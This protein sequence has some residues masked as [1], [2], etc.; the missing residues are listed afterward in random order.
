M[1]A[2][3]A[4]LREACSSD[5]WDAGVRFFRADVVVGVEADEEEI[6]LHVRVGGRPSPYEVHLWPKDEDWS[7]DCGHEEGCAH[8]VAAVLAMRKSKGELP[9]PEGHSSLR[10]RLLRDGKTLRIRREVKRGDSIEPAPTLLSQVRGLNLSA[11]D[12]VI[13]EVLALGQHPIPA[14]GW[15]RILKGW[16]SAGSTLRLEGGQLQASSE[17]ITP[18]VLVRDEGRGFRLSLHRDSRVDERFVG[19]I[20]R[21]GETL[22][23]LGDGGLTATQRRQLA[24]GLVFRPEDA[25]LLVGEVL[26]RLEQQVTVRVKT[27]RLPSATSEPPRLVLSVDDHDDGL[28]VRLDIVYGDP[29]IARVVGDELLLTGEAVPLRDKIR[30]RAL[31][32]RAEGMRLPLGRDWSFEEDEAL[33]FVQGRLADFRG[34]VSGSAGRFAVRGQPASIALV[35]GRLQS[36]ADLDGLVDAWIDGESLVPLADGAGYA[37]MPHAFMA[38]HGH[39]VADLV[40]ARQADGSTPKF[41]LPALAELAQALDHPAPPELGE[42]RELLD[43]EWPTE[44]VPAS[45]QAALRPYQEQGFRWLRLLMRGGLGGIL[46]DDMGLGKTLQAL[47]AITAEGG[48][49]LVIAPTSVIGNWLAE[50]TKFVP[51]LSTNRF[52]GP[53]RRLEEVDITVT[54]YALLRLDPSLLEREWTTVVL[55]EAQA[56]K[57]PESQ[58]AQAAFKLRAKHRMSLTGTPIENRLDELWSQLHFVMPG[59]LG[60]RKHF[61]D[62][63]AR[64]VEHGDPRAAK[65]LRKRIAPFVLRRLKSEVATDLPP[66]TDVVL[67]CPM[68]P[69]Q[70]SLYEGV[71]AAAQGDLA[72]MLGDGKA[73][74]ILEVLLRL[75]QA[76]CHSRLLPG[77]RP[78][79]S[80][81]LE[82]LVEKLTSLA[83]AGHRCL[84]FSQWTSH[85]DLIEERVGELGVLRLD[86]ST[87]NRDGVVAAFQDP[88][89]PPVFLLSLKAGGTGLNLTAADYVFHADP[90]WNPAVE[91]QA[92]DRAHRIG[93]DK[94][95]VS[96]KLISEG[97]VEER[98]LALQ[99]KKRAIA[100]AALGE[101]TVA[102]GLTR[103]DLL[104]LL[105]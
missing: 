71:H 92:I 26:P 55:D 79:V 70:R 8:A 98:I 10:Y 7:C 78:D 61:A 3:F 12:V 19:G 30:E 49:S 101:G 38:E 41:A 35:N 88:E 22:H 59:F 11:E 2:L 18:V 13:D 104:E 21:C 24:E 14:T 86:G 84:V 93:Q 16:A 100:R 80:G 9:R 89:G 64:P 66:R 85:L 34:E 50:C 83:E 90:W 58:T 97:T 42:L 20:G 105:R 73:L 68:P 60:G 25:G 81:K 33:A 27:S 48:P 96:V 43:G 69:E 103:E 15:R 6:R 1:H 32:R 95:V 52:H 51:H 102:A 39:L 44:E 47:C 87:R 99:E 77:D 75:R 65:A 74:E 72:R 54:S 82:V 67:K 36:D 5:I 91:D 37:P 76:A 29:P 57:N 40:A 23:P 17:L 46:A 94:P 62:R 4:A 63:Y 28:D 56:I 31:L 45:V 53:R